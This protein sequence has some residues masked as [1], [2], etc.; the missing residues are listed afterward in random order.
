MRERGATSP[1]LLDVVVVAV[2]LAILL[3]AA[4]RQFP[5]YQPSSPAS[6]PTS[7]K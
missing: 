2:L 1:G 3:Y 4:W 5:A 6:A 7:H